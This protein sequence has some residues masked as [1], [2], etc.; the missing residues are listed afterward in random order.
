MH[1]CLW[2]SI[3][4]KQDLAPSGLEPIQ[5][6]AEAALPDCPFKVVGGSLRRSGTMDK[7]DPEVSKGAT[8]VSQGCWQ[9]SESQLGI[10]WVHDYVRKH[11][12]DLSARVHTETEAQ[13]VK[14]KQ[15]LE[16]KRLRVEAYRKEREAE[17]QQHAEN[18]ERNH[19]FDHHP[20]GKTE[21]PTQSHHAHKP[22]TPRDN[23]R[24]VTPR[25]HNPAPQPVTPKETSSVTLAAAHSNTSSTQNTASTNTQNALLA[26]LPQ[27]KTKRVSVSS[28]PK[29]GGKKGK[30]TEPL[31]AEGATKKGST[32]RKQVSDTDILNSEEILRELQ[33]TPAPTTP[34]KEE[35]ASIH[36]PE[37]VN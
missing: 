10:M 23:H 21:S 5:K 30:E 22:V 35:F 6:L 31:L 32:H 37:G 34:K 29:Q 18:H 28:L 19:P 2:Y 25:D 3:S 9:F 1:L 27:V 33:G 17:E 7:L 16:E 13:S 15:E 14:D 20:P 12:G 36:T 4:N 24:A 26:V 11:L 8:S